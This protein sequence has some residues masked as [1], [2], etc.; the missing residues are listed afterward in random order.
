MIE[1]NTLSGYKISHTYSLKRV[2]VLVLVLMLIT[3]CQSNETSTNS[4]TSDKEVKITETEVSG[5]AA[6]HTAAI[7]IEGMTCERACVSAINKTMKGLNGTE[8]IDIH[9]DTAQTLDT[10][11]VDFNESEITPSEMIQAIQTTNGGIYKVKSVEVITTVPSSGCKRGDSAPIE[12]GDAEQSKN[13]Q[14]NFPSVLDII[15]RVSL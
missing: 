13:S 12:G 3:S 4:S 5:K 8:N 15:K 11:Y 7:V 14:F 10:C 9:F 1:T 6:K 2:S